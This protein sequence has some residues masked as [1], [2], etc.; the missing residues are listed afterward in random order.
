MLDTSLHSLRLVKVLLLCYSVTPT[1]TLFPPQREYKG[2][3]DPLHPVTGTE[4][5][6][7]DVLG[8]RMA[9]SLFNTLEKH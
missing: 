2:E 6:R 8:S 3:Y 4:Q 1:H 9:L 7:R 5:D